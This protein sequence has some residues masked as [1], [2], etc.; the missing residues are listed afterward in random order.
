MGSK[1]FL[2]SHIRIYRPPTYIYLLVWWSALVFDPGF[3]Y[4]I[5]HAL[6]GVN[7]WSP[8]GARILVSP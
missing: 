7:H 1:P 4:I 8:N 6:M 2:D 3:V 5:R